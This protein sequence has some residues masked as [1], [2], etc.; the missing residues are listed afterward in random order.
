M[1][2]VR[3][4]GRSAGIATWFAPARPVSCSQIVTAW[5]TPVAPVGCPHPTSPPV[6]LNGTG[7]PRAVQPAST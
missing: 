7:P 4:K 3:P 5:R 6:V 2:T 1:L